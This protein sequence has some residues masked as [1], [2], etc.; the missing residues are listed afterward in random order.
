MVVVGHVQPPS[1]PG[2]TRTAHASKRSADPA[3]PA[4]WSRCPSDA[5][6]LSMAHE[7]VQ[8]K[9]RPAVAEFIERLWHSRKVMSC[10]RAF[11]PHEEEGF[12]ERRD[13]EIIGLVTFCCKSQAMEVLTLNSTLEGAHIGSSL[14]LTVIDEARSRNMTHMWLTTTN[15]NLKALGF[16]Q[17]LGFRLVEVH[18]GVV[19]DARK[20]KPEIPEYGQAGIPIHD[21]L[22]LELRLK[23]FLD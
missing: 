21:E 17:R 14:I 10:G 8:D 13:D 15:D 22:V 6:T 4:H 1:A 11:F 19:D 2:L 18:P 16:F 7:R 3:S 23:P 12:L 20:I 9:D 5:K